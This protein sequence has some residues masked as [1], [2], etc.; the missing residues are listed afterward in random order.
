MTTKSQT[1]AKKTAVKK[2]AVEKPVVKMA[3]ANKKAGTKKIDPRISARRIE[4][5]RT[6][7]RRRLRTLVALAAVTLGVIATIGLLNSS[8]L[9]VDGIE[10]AGATHTAAEDIERATAIELGLPLVDVDLGAAEHGVERLPWIL[11][12]RVDRRWTGTILVE[13]TEREPV[14]AIATETGFALVD[15]SGRQLEIVDERPPGYMPIAGIVAS[16]SLGQPAPPSAQAVLRLLAELGPQREVEVAQ[17][18]IDEGTLY[19]DLRSGGRV[20]VGDDTALVDKMV[21]LDTI[22]TNVDLRCLWEIDVRVPSAPAVTRLDASGNP[23]ATLT[24]LADCS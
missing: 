21:S 5:K 18:I 13:V 8:M 17:I 1:S 11:D 7:G 10:V 20:N 23:R 19:L 24:N 22:M 2:H 3:E 12:A 4:V 14:S 6:E 15:S 16:G 9:D